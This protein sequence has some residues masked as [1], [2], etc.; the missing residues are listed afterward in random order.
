M[1]YSRLA[2]IAAIALIAVELGSGLPAAQSSSQQVNCALFKGMPT[3]ISTCLAAAIPL[4]GVG[5]ILSLTIVALAYMIGEVMNLQGL[6]GWYKTELWE[7]AKSAMLVASMFSILVIL[8]G[9]AA[10][11][12]G[13]PASFQ[14]GSSAPSSTGANIAGLYTT[15]LNSYIT[16]E[17]N[18]AYNA[19]SGII[20]LQSGVTTVKAT[21]M[22]TWLPLPIPIPLG[23]AGVLLMSLQFGSDA[24]FYVSTYIS[25]VNSVGAIDLGATN[26]FVINIEDFV[27]VPTLI[28][29]QI[30]QSMFYLI[31]YLGFGFF[32]PAGI[33][34]RSIP[35]IRGIGGT[36]V[37]IGLTISIIYPAIL[38]TVNLPITNYINSIFQNSAPTPPSVG[39]C[40]MNFPNDP[41]H[42]LLPAVA[43]GFLTAADTLILGG[44]SLA[45]GGA[46]VPTALLLG[47]AEGAATSPAFYQGFSIGF[48]GSLNSIVPPLDFVTYNTYDSVLQL[49]LLVFDLIIA[50][51]VAGSIA[52]LLG[53][54][55]RL[56]VGKLKLT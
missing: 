52:T 5:I 47:T 17:L 7:T 56:G 37:A 41:T 30:Q 53:G 18:V 40:G 31:V 44:Y 46:P 43:C 33:I 4:S 51:I 13:T 21:S 20:G 3:S 15:V 19:I 1:R 2:L 38:L 28:A 16:P 36:M 12:A 39:N 32:L 11:L 34:M 9:I 23:P 10:A 8:S 14:V 50:V 55:L 22:T 25:G 49:I 48:T 35:F 6:K 29:L 26:S 54:K 45:P 27:M 24:P 42:G